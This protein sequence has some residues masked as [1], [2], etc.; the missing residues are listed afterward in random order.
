M[1]DCL[2]LC[3]VYVPEVWGGK[4]RALDPLELENR[5]LQTVMWLPGLQSGS[6]GIARVLNRRAELSLQP[7]NGIL[8]GLMS[9]LIK[10]LLPG[11]GS[12]QWGVT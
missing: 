9:Q 4:K 12:M 7:H 11:S 10:Y 8:V 5:R 1:Y 3:T 6:P 2:Y